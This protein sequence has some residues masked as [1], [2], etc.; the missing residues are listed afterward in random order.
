MGQFEKLKMR[1]WGDGAMG[2]KGEGRGARKFR[3]IKQLEH[4]ELRTF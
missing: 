4:N 2:R 3:R 1:R